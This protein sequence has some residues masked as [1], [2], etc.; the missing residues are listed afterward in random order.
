M[1]NEYG[2]MNME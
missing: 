1:S 2:W